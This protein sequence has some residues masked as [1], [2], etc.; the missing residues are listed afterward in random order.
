MRILSGTLF[1]GAACLS[2]LTGCSGSGDD[3]ADGGGTDSPDSELKGFVGDWKDKESGAELTISKT[4]KAALTG[5]EDEDELNGKLVADST[6]GVASF[7]ATAAGKDGTS[8]HFVVEF[9]NDES[10]HVYLDDTNESDVP[11]L[12]LAKG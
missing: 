5:W 4:G 8:F 6:D 12:V 7:D 11:P 3:A 10:D 9:R 1:S 2:I